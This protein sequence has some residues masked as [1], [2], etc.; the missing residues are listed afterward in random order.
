MVQPVVTRTQRRIE[1][2][3]A[4]LIVILVLAVSLASFAL[5]VM[6]GRRGVELPGMGGSVQEVR[7]P[8]AATI[9]P[10]AP[11][12]EEPPEEKPALTFYDNLPQGRQA[13]LGS[14]INL[15]PEKPVSVDESAA[16]S[17][18]KQVNT[19]P[20]P[21][22]VAKATPPAPKATAA[23][24]FVV[25]VASFRTIED[26]QKLADRLQKGKVAV[27]IEKADLGEKGV[28]HRVLAG[29]YVDREAAEQVVRE[30]KERERLA[31]LVRRR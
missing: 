14:G 23:G 1:R 22:P 11:P 2:K 16:D 28:W 30:L 21:A 3:Q 6:V 20:K 24:A 31:A 27:F 26:A 13:P 29:P 8:M 25:Q 18:V 10:P 17:P 9:P 4:W 5:G 7:L 15:P 12:K 19:P